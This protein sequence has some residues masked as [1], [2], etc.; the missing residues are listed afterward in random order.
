VSNSRKQL[1]KPTKS[2]KMLEFENLE[3]DSRS[4]VQSPGSVAKVCE[5]VVR[6]HQVT[7]IL[8]EDQNMFNQEMI[9]E[10]LGGFG[11]D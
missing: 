5:L 4:V 3:D 8:T 6:D 10:I 2:L 9:H 1:Q 11:R 7:L